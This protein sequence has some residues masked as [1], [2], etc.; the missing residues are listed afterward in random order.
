[1]QHLMLIIL[2]FGSLFQSSF[3][4]CSYTTQNLERRLVQS[5]YACYLQSCH[6]LL[7]YSAHVVSHLHYS[8]LT[9][10]LATDH[11]SI[12]AVLTSIRSQTHRH[13]HVASSASFTHAHLVVTWHFC[14]HANKSAMPVLLPHHLYYQVSKSVI[15]SLIQLLTFYVDFTQ[16]LLPHMRLHPIPH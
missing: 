15:S 9:S 11:K 12:A 5:R 8:Q 16:L 10:I 7:K 14:C 13:T 6:A 1:V 3:Q 2:S 4:V